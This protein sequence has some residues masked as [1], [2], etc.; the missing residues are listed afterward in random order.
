MFIFYP[1][2]IIIKK[3]IIKVFVFIFSELILQFLGKTLNFFLKEK[4]ITDEQ[5]E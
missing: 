1:S 2:Y 4:D 3:K 5:D